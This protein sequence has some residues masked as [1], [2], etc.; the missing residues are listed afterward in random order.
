MS[1]LTSTSKTFHCGSIVCCVS[2]TL[3]LEPG[4]RRSPVT[5]SSYSLAAYNTAS[6]R[7]QSANFPTKV[8]K[9]FMLATLGWSWRRLKKKREEVEVTHFK[10]VYKW[11]YWIICIK[12]WSYINIWIYTNINIHTG[13]YIYKYIYRYI[14]C[15]CYM[16]MYILDIEQMDP[17][18]SLNMKHGTWPESIGSTRT[19][20]SR[21]YRIDQVE[22]KTESLQS[23]LWTV[24]L[25]QISL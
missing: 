8:T 19:G 15:M 25:I 5:R 2:P 22:R 20:V 10:C 21:A 12:I 11:I 24:H 6:R 14:I 13:V 9:R 18:K 4:H 3:R 7:F 16:Y 17:M 23:W 1:T